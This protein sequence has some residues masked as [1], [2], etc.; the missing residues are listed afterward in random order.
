MV[1]INSENFFMIEDCEN[2]E[3]IFYIY[4]VCVVLKYVMINIKFVKYK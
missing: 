1:K 4:N 2:K 3:W